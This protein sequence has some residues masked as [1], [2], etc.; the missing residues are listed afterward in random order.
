VSFFSIPDEY[1]S[2]FGK[3]G[4]DAVQ[5][6]VKPYLLVPGGDTSQTASQLVAHL[7][8]SSGRW[9]ELQ[10]KYFTQLAAVWASAAAAARGEKPVATVAPERSDRR[11][12]HA[13][14]RDD[15][16]FD[17]LKQSYLVFANYLR[18]LVDS[19]QVDERTRERMRFAA[20]QCID[21]MAPTNYFLG[22]PEAMELAQQ[23]RG[24]SVSEGLRNL[25]ADL[26][27]GRVS[28]T[29]EAVFEV[30]RNLAVSPGAVAF[31][32]ELIQVI[33]YAPATPRVAERPLVIVP[34]SINKFYILDLAPENSFVR[35]A[36][37]QGNTVFM[38]SWRDIGPELGHLGW[39]DYLEL[40]VMQA[41]D[42][43]LRVSGADRV[44]AL[45][46]CVGGTLLGSAAAVLAARG[47]DKLASLTFLTTMLDF[48]DTGDIGLFIDES[49][50]AERERTIGRG[51]VMPGK[52]LAF[53]FSMLRAND[54]VWPY[55]ADNYLKGKTPPAFDLLYW[56]SD[57]TSLPGPMYCWYVRNTYLE[58]KIAVAGG[59]VQ[60]GVQ[61][62]LGKVAVP[63]YVLATRED[64]IVPW[65]S[66]FATTRHLSGETT[67]VLGASGH[68]AGVVNPAS[69]NKRNYRVGGQ[70]GATHT[71]WLETAEQVPGSW[72]PH[73]SEWLR[74]RGGDPVPAREALGSPAHPPT[75]P[76]PGRYVKMR[77]P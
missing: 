65:E 12:V 7:A 61:V 56:N 34:P 44:N 54:L 21:A 58:N 17:L 48:V 11:F 69:R 72:W 52:E 64:H 50:V 6:L 24:E 71:G 9:L 31:E 3:A 53:V 33:Q 14:W 45:G 62:D 74:A 15:P 41:I 26:Q 16:Y 57:S 75:E 29:D 73:W 20:R 8:S 51:G 43:A 18:E 63:A 23:T 67:F 47:E 27:K 5:Q 32:N 2:L 22:N 38:V 70:L 19:A 1:L 35:Y 42:V 37:E 68:I 60:C 13:K 39:D 59:T 76:A 36:V 40:G 25:L 30:G 28:M 49:A 4:R 77:A 10:T 66:A 55:V 46:F